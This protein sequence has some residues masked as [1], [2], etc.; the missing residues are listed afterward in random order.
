MEEINLGTVPFCKEHATGP[1]GKRVLDK[2]ERRTVGV[3]FRITAKVLARCNK[4]SGKDG[5]ASICP[6]CKKG[7][8]DTSIRIRLEG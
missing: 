7:A 2:F 3:A 6:Y 8:N 5:S 1:L 4:S